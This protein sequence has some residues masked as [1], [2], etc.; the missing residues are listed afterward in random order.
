MVISSGLIGYGGSQDDSSDTSFVDMSQYSYSKTTY[1]YLCLLMSI[2]VSANASLTYFGLQ[3]KI[4]TGC[5][6]V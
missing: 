5:D 1:T 4:K 6:L 3:N 2:C